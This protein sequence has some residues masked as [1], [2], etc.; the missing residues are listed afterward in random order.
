MSGPPV[1]DLAHGQFPPLQA[2]ALLSAV[3]ATTSLIKLVT[4]TAGGL[5]IWPS[6][7]AGAI[8][9]PLSLLGTTLGDRLARRLNRAAFARVV[10]AVFLCLG[11]ALF[12]TSVLRILRA[13]AA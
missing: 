12:V 1:A 7:A 5:W 8:V 11:L 10:W 13:D 9:A 3:F 2:R 4:I 6:V